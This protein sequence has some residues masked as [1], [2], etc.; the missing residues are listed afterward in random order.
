MKL[1]EYFKKIFNII[2]L[3]YNNISFRRKLKA[4]KKILKKGILI[5][6]LLK[7]KY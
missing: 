6:F 3:L 7:V 5:Y 1:I 4:N 2:S